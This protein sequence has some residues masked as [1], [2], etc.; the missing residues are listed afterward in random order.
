MDSVALFNLP[1][2]SD[3]EVH[4]VD[5]MIY[6]IFAVLDSK[7]V[8]VAGKEGKRLCF[9]SRYAALHTLREAGITAVTFVHRS[10]YGEMVGLDDAGQT[11]EMRQIIPL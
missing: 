9:P 3:I 10:A 8:P 1:A 7:L 5:P 2:N 11:N 6:L 4:G